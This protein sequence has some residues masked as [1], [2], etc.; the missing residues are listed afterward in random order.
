MHHHELACPAVILEL[1]RNPRV[2]LGISDGVGWLQTKVPSDGVV[3]EKAR[4][5][6]GG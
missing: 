4:R 5:W 6:S 1:I 3:T 2:G